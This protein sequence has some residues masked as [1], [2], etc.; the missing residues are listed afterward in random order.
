MDSCKL[1]SG[2]IKEEAA[3]A[4]EYAVPGGDVVRAHAHAS[5][6][7]RAYA[8]AARGRR[9]HSAQPARTAADT[10]RREAVIPLLC[11]YQVPSRTSKTHLEGDNSGFK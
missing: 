8:H 1:I 3:A 7:A 6:S 2:G 11:T 5:A 10:H 4:G 9:A